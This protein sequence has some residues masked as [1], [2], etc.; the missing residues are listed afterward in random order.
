MASQTEQK[1]KARHAIMTHNQDK[2]TA[3]ERGV[4]AWMFDQMPVGWTKCYMVEV[5]IDDAMNRL[6]SGGNGLHTHGGNGSRC[7]AHHYDDPGW[8]VIHCDDA[9][10]D[11]ETNL[12]RGLQVIEHLQA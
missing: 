1:H 7:Y 3:D 10:W 12:A 8:A 6:L 2:L 9:D 4:I 5:Q 11:Q